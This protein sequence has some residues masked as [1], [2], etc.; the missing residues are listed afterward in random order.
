FAQLCP[1]R[2][3]IG[4]IVLVVDLAVQQ[5]HTHGD[6]VFF[7]DRHDSLQ[8]NGAIF[9]SLLIIQASSIARKANDLRI[10]SFCYL[11]DNLLITSN[12]FIME[13]RVIPAAFYSQSCPL[14][15]R[16]GQTVFFQRRPFIWTQQF[17]GTKSYFFSRSAE[18]F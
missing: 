17:Y 13:S 18:V 8:A 12:Q 11:R 7:G 6:V 1:P 4:L 16:T 14:G 15:H 10:T 2:C 3:M 5:F 9:N